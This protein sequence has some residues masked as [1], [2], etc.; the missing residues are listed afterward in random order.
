MKNRPTNP[1]GAKT[2]DD[3]RLTCSNRQK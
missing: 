1:E 3:W 2:D